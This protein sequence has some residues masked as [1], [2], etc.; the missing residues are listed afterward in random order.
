MYQRNGRCSHEKD[1]ANRHQNCQGTNPDKPA[2]FYTW[3]QFILFNH[4]RRYL[5]GREMF[6]RAVL[7][8]L[9]L[10]AVVAGLVPWLLL[11]SDRWRMGGTLL[12]WPIWF[13]GA[14]VLLWCVRDF[15]KIGK[16]TLAPWDPPKKL[17]V[18]G[19]YRFVRNPMYVGVLGWVAGWSLIAGSLVLGIYTILL[20]IAFHLRVIFYEEPTLARQFGNDWVQYQGTVPRWIP[21]RALDRR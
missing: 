9:A 18:V 11:D 21:T 6:L 17:V 19:L 20:A 1:G 2:M 4:V 5:G 8:F 10:P 12:G 14:C 15:Y 16:G 7:A 13:F 3:R